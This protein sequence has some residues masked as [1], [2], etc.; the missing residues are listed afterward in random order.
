MKNKQLFLISILIILLVQ[1]ASFSNAQTVKNNT[2][3]TTGK[4]LKD[5]AAGG[6]RLHHDA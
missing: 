6:G 1:Y 2:A 3:V 5:Y 4:G